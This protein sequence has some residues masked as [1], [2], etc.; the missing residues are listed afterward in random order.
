MIIKIENNR[1]K[2]ELSTKG[3]EL[4]NLI[5]K[6]TGKDIWVHAIDLCGY[7]TQQFAGKNTNIIAGWSEKV[8][9]F[10]ALAEQGMDALIR[11]I[12]NYRGT[13]Q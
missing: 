5:D 12:S 10:I 6:K 4:Q 9:E 3:G 1:F 11:R 2:A 7:G 13:M 8:F